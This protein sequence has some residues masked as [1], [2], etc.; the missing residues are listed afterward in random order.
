M[1]LFLTPVGYVT[2]C[3]LF[4]PLDAAGLKDHATVCGTLAPRLVEEERF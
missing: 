1:S 3:D 2:M 4:A